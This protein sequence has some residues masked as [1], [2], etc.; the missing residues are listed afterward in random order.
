MKLNAS[1]ASLGGCDSRASRFCISV[2]RW[3]RFFVG[4]IKSRFSATGV[5]CGPRT[6]ADLVAADVTCAMVGRELAIPVR[7]SNYVVGEPV[8]SVRNLSLPWPGHARPWRLKEVSL[9][10]RAGEV[11]GLAGLMGAGRTEL[12][13][14]LFGANTI[15]WSGEIHLRG[16]PTRFTHPRQAIRAGI[17]LVTEDRKQLGLVAAMNVRENTT[18][19]A[20]SRWAMAGV[21]PPWTEQRQTRNT[22]DRLRVK[23]DT[24]EASIGSLS[25]GNQQK[26]LIGRTLLT[27]PRLLLLDDPT[28]GID[29]GAKS[30]LYALIDDL[31]DQGL[32]IVLTQWRI[33]GVAPPIGSDLG[34]GGGTFDRRVDPRNGHRGI[35]HGRR[36]VPATDIPIH[37]CD[38]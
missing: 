21:V 13:E 11:V 19:S 34:L 2:T 30:E 17:A 32:A 35:D 18:L 9:D 5:T 38:R 29:I 15:P 25:G 4:R 37:R 28:R 7:R 26:C 23:C 6:R 12:L 33:A 8:L 3:R 14:C 1:T 10:V 24:P 31:R 27:T 16:K 22:I 20:L 36:H